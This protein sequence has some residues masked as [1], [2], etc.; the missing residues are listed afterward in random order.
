MQQTQSHVRVLNNL[1][2]DL[3]VRY[4][5]AVDNNLRSYCY[6]LQLRLETAES[7]LNL[8]QQYTAQKAEELDAL[9]NS[10]DLV[11]AEPVMFYDS[12]SEWD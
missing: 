4:K 5:R 8:Y 11:E 1:V 7:I 9:S 12:D 10:L 6:T 3:Q 2:H